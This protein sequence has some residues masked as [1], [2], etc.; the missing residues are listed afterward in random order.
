MSGRKAASNKEESGEWSDVSSN[1]QPGGKRK[2]R[3]SKKQ[4]AKPTLTN[5][6]PH[7]EIK[8]L[9]ADQLGYPNNSK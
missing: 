6:A 4:T 2:V 8:R 5:G 9:S 7:R 3:L 1:M